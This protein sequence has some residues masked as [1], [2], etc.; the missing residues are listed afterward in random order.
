VPRGTYL[1]QF[2]FIGPR[3][4]AEEIKRQLKRFLSEDLKLNLSEEKT[5]ITHA[6][7]DAAKFLG[8]EITTLK[9]DIKHCLDKAGIDRRSINGLI[10]LRVPHAVISGKMRPLQEGRKASSPSRVAQ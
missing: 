3:S 8:Y 10:G 9:K 2:A 7:S 1:S 4:E 6:R 5:L